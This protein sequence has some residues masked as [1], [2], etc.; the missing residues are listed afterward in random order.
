M[1]ESNPE[2][3]GKWN[4]CI[5]MNSWYKSCVSVMPEARLSW[6]SYQICK[7]AGCACAW[8]AGNVFPPS[9][10]SDPDMYH[11]TCVTHVLWC[12]PGSLTSG[13]FWS[14]WL[15]KRSRHSRRMHNP[16]FCV[17]GMKPIARCLPLWKIPEDT[18]LCIGESNS[19]KIH[20]CVH[21][22]INL[23]PHICIYHIYVYMYWCMMCFL[24][25][26]ASSQS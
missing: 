4:L 9:R 2:N 3:R 25:D 23:S 11:D 20:V 16:Q 17:S 10:V 24:Y 5:H 12:M 22:Y 21:A 7:I 14:R 18:A 1:A 13:F 15:G 26:I 6:A 19:S 8:N